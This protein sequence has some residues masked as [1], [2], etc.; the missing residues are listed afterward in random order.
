M[1]ENPYAG[2]D[3]GHWAAVTAQLV[4]D[5]PLSPNEIVDLVLDCWRR[6]LTTKVAGELQIGVDVKPSQQMMG[7]FLNDVLGVTLAKRYPGVWRPQETKHDKDLVYIPNA[8]YSTEIKSSS[9]KDSIFAN[10]SYAQPS[11]P[12][13]KPKD[14]YYLAINND[15]MS[16]DNPQ[17][18]RVALGWLAHNDWKPQ[19]SP[20]G[21]AATLTPEVKV[22]KFV[23]LYENRG[24]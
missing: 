3:P 6:I 23:V 11:A 24:S 21:Q 22:G 9:H 16:V 1:L 2:V 14:G 7:N 12:G 4:N 13:T 8:W 10:R 17:I 20:T 15:K 5:Y 19:A 18:R